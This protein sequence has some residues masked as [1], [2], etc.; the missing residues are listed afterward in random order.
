MSGQKTSV[1]KQIRD[2]MMSQRLVATE[3]IRR[4]IDS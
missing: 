2:K 3:Q 1:Q 4:V